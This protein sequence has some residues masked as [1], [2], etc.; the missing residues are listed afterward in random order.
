[1]D[2]KILEFL[3]CFMDLFIRQ[4]ESIDDF[5]KLLKTHLFVKHFN[6]NAFLT[7]VHSLVSFFFSIF[8]ILWYYGA[9]GGQ[10]LSPRLFITQ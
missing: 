5:E 7:F 4:S 9:A 10:I 8:D 1:M 3:L 6:F 2:G